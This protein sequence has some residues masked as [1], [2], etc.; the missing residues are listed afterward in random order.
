MEAEYL[1]QY[2]D[3]DMFAR[4][5]LF[6]DGA[7]EYVISNY[8]EG[9]NGIRYLA[10]RRIVCEDQDKNLWTLTGY[11]LLREGLERWKEQKSVVSFE[12]F[13][14]EAEWIKTN[15]LYTCDYRLEDIQEV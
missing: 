15:R 1:K 6:T 9:E 7:S 8:V 11:Q 5:V 13:F 2:L 10:G 4:R 12:D 14:P 3:G